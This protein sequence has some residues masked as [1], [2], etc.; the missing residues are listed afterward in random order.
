MGS[1]RQTLEVT[2]ALPQT[3]AAADG[4]R[5]AP[6]QSPQV[7][8]TALACD[9]YNPNHLLKPQ[10]SLL[11]RSPQPPA[12]PEATHRCRATEYFSVAASERHPGVHGHRQPQTH[13]L[14]EP[15][16]QQVD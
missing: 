1:R 4:A 10:V 6:S 13:H 3:S 8:Q 2:A 7:C 16:R 11:S 9:V 5:K 14:L 12:P 15:C